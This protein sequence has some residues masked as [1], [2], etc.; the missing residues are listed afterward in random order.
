MV[1]KLTW[2]NSDGVEF[3]FNEENNVRILK[4]PRGFYMPPISY[5][6]EEVPF[7]SGSRLRNVKVNTR[8]MDLP[9]KIQCKTPVELTIKLRETLRFFN[10]LKAD[11]K[12]VSIKDDKSQRE[13]K[14]R[15]VGG[16]EMDESAGVGGDT[17]QK[18][19]G[20]FR[21]FD[22]FW[23][24][25]STNVKEFKT[26]EPATF[27]PFFPLRLSS[28]AVF[29]DTTVDNT[30]DVETWPEWI[31]KGPGENVVLRNLTT[32][33]ITTIETSIGVGETLTI[34]TRPFHKTVKK[35]NQ[36]N[37]FHT[38]TDDS[39]LWALQEGK[40]SI[41]IEMSNATEASSIQLSYRNR[42]WGP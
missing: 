19:I 11:G 41:R 32:G 17:W 25:T 12:L 24:D 37:M 42:Y 21:A 4:G 5:M 6:D 38:L 23:Y 34:D 9:I 30:G 35:N 22:P 16:F 14:C 15:Y 40:N 10:P 2:V 39:S 18:A 27:F 28:S 29:A 7:Q 3:P 1:K 8:E 26:G 13:I 36:W 33:E 20:V 31:I